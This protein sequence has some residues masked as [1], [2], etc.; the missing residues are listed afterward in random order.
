[1]AGAGASWVLT[2]FELIRFDAEVAAIY[3]IRS[4]P[5]RV[6]PVDLAAIVAFALA[7]TLVAC[8]VPAWRAARVDPSAALRYE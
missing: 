6:R 4:V 1:A 8:L 7:V 2:R 5:F 3:F